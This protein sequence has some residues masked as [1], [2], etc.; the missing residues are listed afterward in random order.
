MEAVQGLMGRV[1][2]RS[3]NTRVSGVSHAF[4]GRSNSGGIA[5]LQAGNQNCKVCNKQYGVWACGEFKKLEVSKR[6]DFA[7]KIKLCFCCLSEGH[8]GQH[9]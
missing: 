1:E 2:A 7:K 5:E 9:C 8:F 6:W 3:N 4:F